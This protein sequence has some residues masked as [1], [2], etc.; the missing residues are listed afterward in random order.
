[1]PRVGT[2]TPH[3]SSCGAPISLGAKSLTCSYQ[4]A[5][6][7][8]HGGATQTKR[9]PSGG[10]QRCHNITFRREQFGPLSAWR[11]A[12]RE[13][14]SRSAQWSHRHVGQG[15]VAIRASR[16]LCHAPGAALVQGGHG[17]VGGCPV[18]AVQVAKLALVPA[19]HALSGHLDARIQKRKWRWDRG[20]GC[21]KF[22]E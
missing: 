1:M 20:W 18:N 6:M 22:V 14:T 5:Y 19:A 4:Q 16:L 11:H 15:L 10:T 9:L 12:R 2:Y 17:V 3:F 13:Q 8:L 21:S 7:A